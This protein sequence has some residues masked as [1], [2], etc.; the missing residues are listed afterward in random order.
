MD[1]STPAA[2]RV[3]RNEFQRA[4]AAYWD[5][6]QQDPV[7]L[8][9]GDVDGLYHHHYGIGEVDSTVLQGSEDTLEERIIKELHRLET[10]QADLL[11]DHLGPVGTHDRLLDAG[12]GR[13]GT[14]IMAHERLG[15]AVDGV[16]ISQYQVEF[17][18]RQ[19][20][21]LGCADRV[22]FHF[23]NM[24]DTGLPA[25]SYRGIWT[26]ETTMYVDLFDLFSEFARL[27]QDG[28][29]YVCITGCYNDVQ[30]KDPSAAVRRINE[31]Y[32][33]DIH[34]RSRY[35]TAMAANGLVPINV[36]DLTRATLPYWELR[37][38]A[39][40][41]TGI[42]EAFLTAYREESF[43]YLLIAADRLPDDAQAAAASSLRG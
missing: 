4:V 7:N 16:T 15:C 8:R 10:A 21:V 34:P 35:F 5:T 37:Q 25:G 26:N 36:V 23:R 31:H 30:D 11:L 9:L 38:Q 13:G 1:T 28:G 27:L 14:S 40:V 39:S 19:A 32:V 3:L 42:E 6:N 41:K 43:H 24:L 20:K 12:S 22:R 33:C 29:R 17:S 18:R 2:E